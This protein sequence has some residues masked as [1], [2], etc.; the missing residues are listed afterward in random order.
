MNSY[1]LSLFQVENSR[2]TKRVCRMF[3]TNEIEV[4]KKFQV[5]KGDII[6]KSP[7]KY[8][9][10]DGASIVDCEEISDSEGIPCFHGSP[11]LVTDIRF[12]PDYW[13]DQHLFFHFPKKIRRRIIDNYN[14]TTKTS[15]FRVGKKEWIWKLGYGDFPLSKSTIFLCEYENFIFSYDYSPRRYDPLISS[16]LYLKNKIRKWYKY[17]QG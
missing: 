12:S 3:V 11:F 6:I 5:K 9:F 1:F 14:S 8:R 10:W 15:K 7:L 17:H 4:D 2:R 13:S 16:Y